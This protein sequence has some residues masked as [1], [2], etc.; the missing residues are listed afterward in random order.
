MRCSHGARLTHRPTLGYERANQ[1]SP[2]FTYAPQH[3]VSSPTH[4]APALHGSYSNENR[5]S[6]VLSLR[7]Q[8]CTK[9]LANQGWHDLSKEGRLMSDH[10]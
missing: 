6:P 10:T 4:Q 7:I 8:A 5:P 2:A 1:T 3:R 9:L